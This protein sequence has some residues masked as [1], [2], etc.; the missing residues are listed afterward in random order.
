MLVHRVQNVVI[1]EKLQSRV[2]DTDTDYYK[3]Y[4]DYDDWYVSCY[5]DCWSADFYYKD[6]YTAKVQHVLSRQH[7]F[8][9]FTAG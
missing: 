7:A 3:S 9:D 4:N 5:Y 2:R 6:E 8:Y 1:Q